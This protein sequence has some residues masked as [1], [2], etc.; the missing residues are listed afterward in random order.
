MINLD[1]KYYVDS[2]KYSY[3]L[4]TQSGVDKDGNPIWKP[5]GYFTNLDSIINSYTNMVLRDEVDKSDCN[6]NDLMKRLG[7]LRNRY[8]EIFEAKYN[9]K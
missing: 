1:G 8:D 7:E 3:K 9:F 4:V 5:L 6:I 2:D